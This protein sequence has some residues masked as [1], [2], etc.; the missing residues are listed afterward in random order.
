MAAVAYGGDELLRLVS[1]CQADCL[2]LDLEMPGRNGLELIPLVRRLQPALKI[3]VV[4]MFRDRVIAE[5]AMSEGANGFVPKDASAD[6]L[7]TA[8][9]EV[10]AARRYVSSLLPKSSHRVGLGAQHLGL[11]R[12]TPRQQ[13][14]VLL[15]GE[16]RSTTEVSTTVGLGLSTI[17]FHKHNI[18]RTLGINTDGG[19][20][21]YAVLVRS[22]MHDAE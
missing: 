5:A 7:R 4:T 3:L 21:R 17:T 20:I 8:V 11:H 9:R 14:I 16:G 12:L 2:L 18:M 15:L 6:E 13:Q 1:G 19:L 22:G 10:L